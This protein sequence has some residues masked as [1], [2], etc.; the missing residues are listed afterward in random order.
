MTKH[1][2][3]SSPAN[4]TGDEPAAGWPWPADRY[5][6]ARGDAVGPR[7]IKRLLERLSGR[8][9]PLE[10][11]EVNRAASLLQE[12]L[13]SESPAQ[14]VA[15]RLAEIDDL[16]PALLQLNIRRA[17]S[18]GRPDLA[19]ALGHLLDNIRFQLDMADAGL[20][21]NGEAVRPQPASPDGRMRVLVLAP[22]PDRLTERLSV[23]VGGLAAL[24]CDVKAVDRVSSESLGEV[25]VVLVQDPHGDL[26]IME[27]LATCAAARI[28]ILLDLTQA[29]EHMPV[30]HPEHATLGLGTA[31]TARAY[32]A[33][34]LMVDAVSVP[35][36]AMVAWLKEIGYPVRFVPE[37]WD[38]QAPAWKTPLPER[39]TL[40]LGWLGDPGQIDDVATIR[41]AVIRL[42]REFPDLHL[43]MAGDPEAFQLFDAL[44]ENRRRFL[45]L[46]EESQRPVLLA[47]MDVLLVPLRDTPFNQ[48]RGD[49]SLLEAGVRGIPWVASPTRA[50]RNWRMGGLLAEQRQEWYGHLQRLATDPGLRLSLGEAGRRRAQARRKEHVGELWWEA[51]QAARRAHALSAGLTHPARRRRN[52][53]KV[54][55]R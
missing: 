30:S 55:V 10:E 11:Q 26:S 24:G 21:L 6:A 38:P 37:G 52:G 19:R 2:S 43:V 34:M 40:H 4:L 20:R 49:R 46:L 44:P 17:L 47:Q 9:R 29:F 25:D 35:S 48:A 42:L 33:A 5:A 18:D 8:A 16:I 27:N 32:A 28:P 51:L 15:E 12:I 3:I 45:P 41:R 7:E 53:A 14:T 23:A 22:Q 31:M 54:P 36:E 50:H 39:D 1:H 13:E